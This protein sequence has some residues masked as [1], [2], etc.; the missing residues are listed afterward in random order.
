MDDTKLDQ[1]VHYVCMRCD[2]PG[3]L[4]ATK[5]NKVLWYSDVF[6]FAQEGKSITGATYVKRQ[7]GPVPRD[8][9]ASR[10]RLIAAG[11]L[12]ERQAMSH[13]YPQVQFI[14]LRPAD[15]SMFS[16]AQISL[17][18]GVLEAICSGHTAASISQLSHDYV[19]ESAAIGEEIPMAAAAF[20][21]NF[22]EIDEDDLA[23]AQKEVDRIESRR[24][25]A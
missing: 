17:V 13:G 20:G 23:W 16:G 6:A 15:I 14:A 11:I 21:G 5:L 8:I 10:E 12:V 19:W 3:K 9:R 22:G 1:L 24:V 25:A 4:G 2:N 18:D 7:F